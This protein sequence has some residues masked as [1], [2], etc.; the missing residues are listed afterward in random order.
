MVAV[1]RNLMMTMTESPME[2][3]NVPIQP[4]AKLLIG[5]VVL[6]TKVIPTMMV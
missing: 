2:M 6:P 4:L 5:V 3:M 1:G